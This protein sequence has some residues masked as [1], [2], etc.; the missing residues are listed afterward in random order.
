MPL[1]LELMFFRLAAD[2]VDQASRRRAR[3]GPERGRSSRFRRGSVALVYPVSG[4]TRALQG[5]YCVR[6]SREGNRFA[7]LRL[8]PLLPTLEIR[9]WARVREHLAPRAKPTSFAGAGATPTAVQAQRR[10]RD[11]GGLLSPRSAR[12]RGVSLTRRSG[13]TPRPCLGAPVRR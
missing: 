13:R 5:G 9:H 3:V 6:R 4:V 7:V 1:T 8:P 11:R 12:C 2:I 10:P